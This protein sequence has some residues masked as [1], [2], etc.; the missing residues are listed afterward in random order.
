MRSPGALV[1]GGALTNRV[2]GG[3]MNATDGSHKQRRWELQL[4][5]SSW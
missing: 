2:E 1:P 5:N 3:S 4:V